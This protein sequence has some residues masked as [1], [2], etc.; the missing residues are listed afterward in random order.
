MEGWD[1]VQEGVPV[2]AEEVPEHRVGPLQR[3]R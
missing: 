1:L 2:E 3:R